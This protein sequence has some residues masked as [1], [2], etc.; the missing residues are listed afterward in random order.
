M[1]QRTDEA[2]QISKIAV[3]KSQQASATVN[4]FVAATQQIDSIVQMIE[5][6]AVKTNLL[7]LNAG[8]EAA[9][10][11][12]AGRGF[13]VVANEVKAL[14][15]QTSRATS[16]ITALIEKIQSQSENAS[17]SIDKI[18][19]AVGKTN[20]VSL[21]ISSTMDEQSDSIRGISN[22]A[23]M[24][25]EQMQQIDTEIGEVSGAT[26]RVSDRAAHLLGA[27]AELKNTIALQQQYAAGFVSQL[28]SV[29]SGEV[30]ERDESILSEEDDDELWD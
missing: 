30:V 15:E 23:H 2:Y 11:G 13:A 12:E 3:E 14:S 8:I 19:E 10:A 20:E 4:E 18:G 29:R 26:N 27:V 9:R 1:S 21:E 6:I 22:S 17:L 25:A 5:G 24:A 16:E 7:A 28:E